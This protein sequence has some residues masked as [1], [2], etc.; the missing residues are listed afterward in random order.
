M[1]I[2]EQKAWD[3]YAALAVI[4]LLLIS[5]YLFIIAYTLNETVNIHK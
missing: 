4:A 1:K 2:S 3:C 5:A